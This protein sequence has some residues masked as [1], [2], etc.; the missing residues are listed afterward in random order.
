SSLS[1]LKDLPIDRLKIDR[2]FVQKLTNKAS[3]AAIV[4]AIISMS[5]TLDLKIT[6]EG[7]ETEE[8][9]ASLRRMGCEEAQG[10][11]FSKP[12]P[13]AELEPMLTN[14]RAKVITFN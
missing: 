11:L 10:Y 8:Q 2:S 13:F 5:R 12:M 1:V 3:D 9:S 4:K 7:V 14:K 6:A